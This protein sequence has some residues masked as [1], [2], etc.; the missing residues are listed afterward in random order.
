MTVERDGSTA[1]RL[2]DTPDA[3]GTVEFT[4]LLP[5]TYRV[6]VLR[7]LTAAETAR[8]DSTDADVFAFGGG[9]SVD[10]QPPIPSRM[11]N[12]EQAQGAYHD[13]G[14]GARGGLVRA[15]ASQRSAPEGRLQR[16][17]A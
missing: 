1:S 9:L 2:S 8:F 12:Y 11:L 4:G 13:E 15:V 7:V 14:R 17:T 6:S 10:V 16:I 3:T 5:G